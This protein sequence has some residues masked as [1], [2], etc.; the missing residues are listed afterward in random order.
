MVKDAAAGKR[1]HEG[2]T[3][4]MN[5]DAKA[6]LGNGTERNVLKPSLHTIRDAWRRTD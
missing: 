6:Q 1:I 5:E 3:T 4:K 2:F